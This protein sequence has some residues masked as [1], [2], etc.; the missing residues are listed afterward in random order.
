MEYEISALQ[1]AL[2]VNYASSLLK[3][4]SH[5]AILA[6]KCTTWQGFQGEFAWQGTSDISAWLA[7][8]VALQ[9]KEALGVQRLRKHNHDKLVEAVTMLRAAWGKQL[10]VLGPVQQIQGTP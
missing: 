5:V 8:P 9:L 10:I 7:V 1:L 2:P 6:S 4:Q 3:A